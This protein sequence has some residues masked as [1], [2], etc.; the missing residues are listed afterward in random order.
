MAETELDKAPAASPVEVKG[1][2]AEEEKP[3]PP[4]VQTPPPQ[5]WPAPVISTSHSLRV[6]FAILCAV[7]SLTSFTWTAI[8]KVQKID[9]LSLTGEL[10]FNEAS[11]AAIDLRISQ[12]GDFL[13]V[14]ILFLGGLAAL[15]IA[16]RDEA[17]IGLADHPE[18]VMCICAALALIGSWIWHEL[19]LNELS[20]YLLEGARTC[21][22]KDE[23]CV[24]DVFEGPLRYLF[25][26]QISFLV[27]GAVQAG[28]TL[29]SA[30]RLKENR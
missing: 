24:P 27:L 20:H 2:P 14:C 29:V 25:R 3:V 21:F 28:I 18:T 17:R 6:V 11:K 26:F 7:I 19:Y 4:P 1:A 16:K 8:Y 23:K 9:P 13:K 5:L 30:H 22:G 10:P 15:V 12:S